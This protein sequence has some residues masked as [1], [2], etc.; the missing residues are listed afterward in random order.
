M[1]TSS[2]APADRKPEWT[3]D[4]CVDYEVARECIVE[5]IAVR[6]AW[7]D[8]ERQKASPDE[9]AMAQWSA[10][11]SAYFAELRALSIYDPA[12]S[13]RVC[14]EYGPELK[15]LRAQSTPR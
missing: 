2:T 1:A 11:Q 10:D 3:H 8:A 9:T 12:N 15:R 6:S 7:L 13:A 5:M 14:R 4:E